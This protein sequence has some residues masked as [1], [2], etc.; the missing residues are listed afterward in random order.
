MHACMF[1][2]IGSGVR[3]NFAIISMCLGHDLPVR[4]GLLGLKRNSRRFWRR[5][6]Q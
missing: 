6:Y 2:V 1:A 4:H 5:F 3:N